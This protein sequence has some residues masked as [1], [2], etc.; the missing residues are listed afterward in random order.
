[1]TEKIVCFAGHRY[2]W[3][4]IGI[5]EKL[6]EIIIDLIKQ[7]Y[8]TFYEG[9]NGYFDKLAS[10]IL[11]NLKSKYPHIKIFRILSFYNPSQKNLKLHPA[12]NGTILPDLS[13]VYYKQ[14]IIKM[15][16]WIIDNS[17]VL[18]CHILHTNNSGAFLTVKYAQSTKIQIIYI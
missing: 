4:N 6:K 14:K 2:E 16:Q 15:N 5:E 10:S 1:M 8:N 11:I 13:N 3:H 12:Y 9:N 18:V 17:S 7:G